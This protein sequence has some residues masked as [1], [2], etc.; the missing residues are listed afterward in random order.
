MVLLSFLSSCTTV[1]AKKT[2]WIQYTGNDG[3]IWLDDARRPALYTG[4]FGD[5]LGGSL[6]NLTRFDASYYKDNMTVQ[7]HLGGSSALLDESVM[8]MND[9]FCKKDTANGSQCISVFMHTAKI[10]LTSPSTLAR[11]TST[12]SVL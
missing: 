2:R 11:Q 8:S 3:T 10:G 7:F 1:S 6:I 9:G 12:V 4:E 5:C